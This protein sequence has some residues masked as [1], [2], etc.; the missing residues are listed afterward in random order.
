ML[1]RF[2]KRLD[3]LSAAIFT[4]AVGGAMAAVVLMVATALWQVVAR[5]VLDQPPPWTEELAR[6]S[7]V[8]VG[9]LGASCAFRQNADPVLFPSM[10]LR[11]GRVGSSLSF[12]R[13]GGV[14][15]FIGPII[16]FSLFGRGADITRGYIARMTG[17][18]A[19]TM[20]IPMVV[21]AVAIPLSF[22][23]ILIHLAARVA[24]DLTGDR[25]PDPRKGLL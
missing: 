24:N 3:A 16:W 23:F 17:R 5:Y 9:L 10:N 15:L 14:L 2:A 20:D 22:L 21:F 1:G 7:M 12:I 8:W 18:E 19:L 11:R 25:A 4:V 13:A 6:Y